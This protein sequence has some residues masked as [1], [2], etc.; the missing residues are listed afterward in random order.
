MTWPC[1]GRD[2]GLSIHFHNNYITVMKNNNTYIKQ[3]SQAYDNVAEAYSKDSYSGKYSNEKLI[4]FISK[5][6]ANGSI[7]DIG[8]GGGPDTLFFSQK[9][10]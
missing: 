9:G 5:L 3:M 10:F 7:L 6:P 2:K 8:C 4:A 1:F